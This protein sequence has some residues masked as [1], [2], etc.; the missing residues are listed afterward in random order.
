MYRGDIRLGNTID[1][2]F[3]TTSATTGAPTQL[4]GSPVVSAYVG[5]STTE[6][7]AGITLTVDFDGRTGLNN[8]RVVASGGN[9]FATATDVQLVITTGTVGGT[10]VVGYVVA[11]FSIENRSALMP[12]T[13]ARTLD[14]T[15]TGEAGID[16]GNVGNPTTAVNLSATNIDVDQV[17][18]SVSGAVGSVTGLTATNLD[19]AVST[20][21]ATYTQPTGFLA[22]TF[23]TTVA[24]T[25][26]ITAGT[27]TNVTTVNGLAANVITASSLATDAVN[28]IVD[29]VWDEA[30]A[31]H[32]SAGS[33]GLALNSAGSAGD[34]WSTS[35]PGAYGAGTA[36][37]ILGNNLDVAVS[38]LATQV[39]VD[40]VPTATENADALLNRDFSAVTDSN[41]RTLLQAARFLRN[42]WDITGTSLVVMK[43]D[44]ATTAWTGTVTP[45][46][47]ADPI[48]GNDPT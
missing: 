33:T 16:W 23:P 30:I 8:V 39:S 14:V 34:P 44:D 37:N 43:E 4:A 10:S 6:I 48:S 7:T 47:G 46:P 11:E 31:G 3:V 2:K 25:T 19:V 27:I 5:N 29:G 26:N 42:K 45:A 9:G 1:I 32:L 22:A 12:T 15:A 21:M 36:G 18:A 41:D 38:T 24:S 35:L 13:A 20:R 28:E 17:V 40:A